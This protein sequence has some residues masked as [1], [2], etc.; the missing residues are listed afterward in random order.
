MLLPCFVREC[1]PNEHYRINPRM[2]CRSMP[3]NSAAF[4]QCTQ[5]VEFYFVPYRLLWTSFPQ[6]FVG[7]KFAVTTKTTSPEKETFP[8]FDLGP[9]KSTDM[10]NKFWYNTAL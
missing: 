1:N 9:K 6:W 8:T 10:P 2:F 5:N 4:I 7:T 3:M